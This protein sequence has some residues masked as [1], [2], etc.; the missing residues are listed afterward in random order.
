MPTCP[1]CAE[2]INAGV[3]QCPYCR[4]D[5]RRPVRQRAASAAGG[6][7]P[8]KSGM[9]GWIILL[10]VGGVLATIAIPIAL[11]VAL[12]LP[13][14]SGAREAARRT[15][16]K[17]NLKQ[18]GLALHNYHEVY[19]SFPPAYIADK[20]G[21]PMHSWRVLILP[22]LGQSYLYDI[23]DFSKPWDS[24][25]NRN[26]LNMMPDVYR[27]PSDVKQG[28]PSTTTSYAA[29]FGP[30]CV[31]R[32]S[33]PVRIPDIADG[34]SN[35]IIVGEASGAAIPWTKPVDVDVSQFPL[36]G[37]PRGFSSEH[38]GGCQILL[39]DGSVRFVS[40][41]TPEPTL[42]ALYTFDGN[43]TVLDY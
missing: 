7:R 9:S 8:V 5:L 26:V 27:C 18:I 41:H 23:Y 2:T 29:S 32:G 13:A 34:T 39:G 24:P 1:Y 22:Y 17:N 42:R 25:E 36:V 33:E 19:G 40:E 30:H 43:E 3:T 16:C 31:F 4:S 20:D 37:D 28:A 38:K 15:A 11:M 10:I 14:V 12:L 6:M 35:T 21:K